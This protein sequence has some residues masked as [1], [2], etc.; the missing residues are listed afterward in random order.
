MIVALSAMTHK[1]EIE[2]GAKCGMDEFLT[3][4][5]EIDRLRFVLGK[6]FNQ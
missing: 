5:P 6:R 3:K 4:P 1:T 2:K